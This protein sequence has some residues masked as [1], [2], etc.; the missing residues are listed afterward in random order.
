MDFGSSTG[1]V[2]SSEIGTTAVGAV[3]A[4]PLGGISPTAACASPALH[5]RHRHSGTLSSVQ[6]FQFSQGAVVCLSTGGFV[7]TVDVGHQT[8][9]T[10]N[11]SNSVVTRPGGFFSPRTGS[12]YDA[13]AVASLWPLKVGKSVQFVQHLDKDA[14]RQTIKVLRTETIAT[15]AGRFNTFVVQRE[16]RG[17]GATNFL[18]T[19]TYW[20]AP[21]PG[22]IVKFDVHQSAGAAVAE[23]P[24]VAVRVLTAEAMHAA[25]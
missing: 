21:D 3:A 13:S 4:N 16:A 22:A 8:V 11:A 24:W 14:W 19:Y 2:A 17:L 15:P 6:P 7:K 1:D 18:A 20:Y 5:E 12:L 23:K 25:N 9:T 10:V